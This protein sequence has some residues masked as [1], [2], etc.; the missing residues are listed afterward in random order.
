M[1]GGRGNTG[2]NEK[3]A[4]NACEISVELFAYILNFG[5]VDKNLLEEK[6]EKF[7]QGESNFV[8]VGHQV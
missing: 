3:E 1:H 8:E 6:W 4:E 2:E 5:S 7:D